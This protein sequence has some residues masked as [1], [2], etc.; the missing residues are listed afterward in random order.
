MIPAFMVPYKHYSAEVIS[1]VIDG[2][3]TADDEDSENHPSEWTMRRWHHWFMAN[4]SAID[5]TLRSVGFR[6]LGFSEKLLKS[7]DSL[8]VK[9]RASLADWLETV[10]QIVYNSGGFL[11]PG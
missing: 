3:V 1:G 7:G 11:V 9:I 10:L 2:V 6:T 4:E 5:G 8:L